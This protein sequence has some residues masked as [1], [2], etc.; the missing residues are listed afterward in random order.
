MKNKAIRFSATLALAL[1]FCLASCTKEPEHSHYPGK[2]D[3]TEKPDKPDQPGGEETGG[4]TDK[5]TLPVGKK[6]LRILFIGNSFTLDATEQLPGILNAAGATDI[7][8]E[9]AYHGAYTMTGYDTNFS[10]KTVCMRHTWKYGDTYWQGNQSYTAANYVSS[11]DDFFNGKPYD[12]VVLQEYTNTPYA[13][14]GTSEELISIEAIK[15]LKKK[16]EA[17]QPGKKPCFVYLMSH[18]PTNDYT[19][20]DSRWKDNLDKM[21]ESITT[22]AQKVLTDCEIDYLIPTGTMLENLRTSSINVDNGMDLSR[23]QLHMDKGISRYGANCTVFETIIGPCIGKTMDDN[24]YRFTFSKSDKTDWWTPVTDENAPYALQA[25]RYA[26]AKPYEITDMSKWSPATTGDETLSI[27]FIGN[28]FTLDATEHLPGILDAAGIKNV[29]LERAYHGAQTLS[30]YYAGFSTKVAHRNSWKSGETGWQ[31]GTNY[32][33]YDT[34]LDEFFDGVSYD[35]IVLQEATGSTD[36]YAGISA[37]TSATGIAATK[38]MIKKV[39]D[40]QPGKRPY[41]VYMMTQAQTSGYPSSAT[42]IHT[43]FGGDQIKMYESIVDHAKAVMEQCEVDKLVATGT[44][45][46]NLRTSAINT[47]KTRDMTRGDGKH[48]DQGI[49]RYGAACTVF[50]SIIGPR[51]GKNMDGNSYRFVST[52]SLATTVS[53]ANAPYALQAAR[54]AIEKPYEITDMTSWSP[55]K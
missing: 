5:A 21:Y 26:I 2:G 30:K 6:D 27:L 54:Y 29:T 28:S 44:M 39:C 53:D 42:E 14:S 31:G 11:L 24:T 4:D 43:Y 18:L 50:E 55:A 51:V 10:S 9:R 25:A 40:K 47:D 15:S 36:S 35:I 23:D 34:T 52:S 32:N 3:N 49:S 38:N 48:M 12:I 1:A 41:I 37:S 20:L 45:L 17:K 19:K 46:Q 33:T 22:H 8:M 13:W 7:T 16:I